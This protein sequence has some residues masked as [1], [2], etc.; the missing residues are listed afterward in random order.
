MYQ[1]VPIIDIAPFLKG[2]PEEKQQ[3]A[4]EVERAC[5]EI[6]FMTIVGHGIPRTLIDK[7]YQTANH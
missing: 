7:T 2:S 1:T 6:G 5:R 4:A 3:V